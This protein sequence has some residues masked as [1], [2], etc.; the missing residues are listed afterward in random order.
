M[1]S[2]LF[3]LTLL[4]GVGCMQVQPVGPFAKWMAKPK[5]PTPLPESVKGAAADEP[6]VAVAPRRPAPPAMLIVP[7]DVTPDNPTA[8]VDKLMNELEADQKT[9]LPTKTAEISIIK[10]GVKQ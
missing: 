4:S 10:G 7:D 5:E 6:A 8:A 1:R 2:L 9:S 3:G